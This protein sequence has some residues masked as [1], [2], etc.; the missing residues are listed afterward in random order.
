[1]LTTTESA[2]NK[3]TKMGQK[4]DVAKNKINYCKIK[5]N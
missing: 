5:S 3:Y 2:T 4:G 1:M